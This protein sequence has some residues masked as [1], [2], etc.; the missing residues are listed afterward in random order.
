MAS[1]ANPAARVGSIGVRLLLWMVLLAVI[2]WGALALWIDGPAALAAGFVAISVALLI[3]VRPFRRGFLA[4]LVPFLVILI[5][6][7][8]IPPRNDRDWLPD[9]ARLPR[10]TI[11]GGQVTIENLRNFDY[12]SETD[13][14]E[15]WETRTFDLDH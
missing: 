1:I 9:V 14:T 2:G 15:R 7:S 10:A 4:G 8:M 11:T 12:R 3:C 5:W 13:Y 6:W